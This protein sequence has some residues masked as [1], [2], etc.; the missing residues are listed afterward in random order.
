MGKEE[1][2]E[3]RQQLRREMEALRPID[4]DALT[5]AADLIENFIT[6]WQACAKVDDPDDARQQLLTKVIDRVFVH[7]GQVLAVV[8]HGD[9]GIVLGQ[10]EKTPAEV[11]DAVLEN[12]ASNGVYVHR[13]LFG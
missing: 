9:F 8:L 11:A 5:E 4:Y 6:Y 1:Y 2:V 12:L 3:K 13:S 10:Q 7:A